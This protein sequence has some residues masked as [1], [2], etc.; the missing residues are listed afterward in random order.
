MTT[1]RKQMAARIV[2]D[3][4]VVVGLFLSNV[5]NPKPTVCLLAYP[6]F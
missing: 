1:S 3:R 5:L 6:L 4:V 2:R